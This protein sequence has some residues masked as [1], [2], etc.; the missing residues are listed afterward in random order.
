M[1]IVKPLN[2]LFAK[3]FSPVKG[4]AL[5]FVMMYV[6]SCLCAWITLPPFK[7][8][9]VYENL[10]TEQFVDLY[11]ICLLLMLVPLKAR[12]WVR[13]FLYIILYS[14]ALADT[15][16]F[17]KFGST[18]NPSMLMLVG[19][20]NSREALDFI[21]SLLSADFLFSNV[22]W[23]I[24]LAV[25]NIFLAYLPRIK[26]LHLPQFSIEK[27]YP[28]AGLF[29]LFMIVWGTVASAHNKAA[30]W[31]LMSGRSI[32]EVEHTLTE[33]DHAV[34]YTPFSRL[35]FSIYA[36]KL[37]AKQVDKLVAASDKVKVDSCSFR[38]PNIVLI[39]G[40]SYGKHHSQQ[41][42]Y[43][44]PTTPRQ[45]KREHRGFLVPYS[46]VV[47]PWNLTSY[48]F[49]N[50][51][52]MHV[53]GQQGDWC[54][55]PLFPE[56]FRKAGYKVQFLTNQF[57]IEANAAVYDFSGGFFL[58]NPTLNKEQ[59]DLRNEKLHVFDEDLL[60]DYDRF[61]KE[62][63]I[64]TKGPNLTIFHL[65]GQHVNYRTRCPKKQYKF[66]ADDY[67]EK[68]PELSEKQR[69]ILS[70]YDNAVRYND[71]IVDQICKRFENKDAIVIYMP[72]HGEECYEESRGFI[73]RN[74]SAAIDWPLAHYE[75]EIPF[76]I[77]CSPKYAHR[78]PEIF[79]EVVQARRRRFMT[80]ALSHMLLYLAGIQA[81]DYH[82]EYNI[83]S[84]HYD[85]M[86]PRILKATTDYDK[87]REAYYKEKKN[88]K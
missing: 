15:Y 31:K 12:R 41:Y 58:N 13:L 17:V 68:R 62:G 76:W 2:C 47:A 24:L 8:A 19:E 71:S 79:R 77:Y 52:S 69:T 46:D 51:F 86:R 23:I 73:C 82:P 34:L 66:S 27:Y 10:Y 33:K 57:L 40:E 21:S 14:V 74:H 84:D 65:I 87:L 61:V 5:F 16:C 49:K 37:A 60:A 6:L 39:I 85:E 25:F 70:Y 43:F 44:M 63:K 54:D 38:S 36:N 45:I 22:G 48:V 9:T 4:N 3:I 72:D 32:G 1:K 80:D 88:K 64:D 30:T 50:V 26:R 81:K 75:F 59:F 11:V 42:G 28:L 7:G 53:V 56:L 29:T 55:Y 67:T 83:L 35:V 18:L 78:H 20:T